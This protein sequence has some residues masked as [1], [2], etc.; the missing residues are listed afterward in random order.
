MSRTIVGVM[1]PGESATAADCA[2][3][4]RLGHL[5]ALQGWVTLTGGRP[6]GVMEAA[7]RG[8]KRAGGTTVGVL[9]ADTAA[10]ASDAA[11]IR[12]VTGLGEG[13]NIINVLSSQIVIVCGMSTGTASETALALKTA[14]H[15]VLLNVPPDA[16]RF[17]SALGGSF[18]HV[19]S[20]PEEAIAV[21]SRLLTEASP[22][23]G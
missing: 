22:P 15:T 23:S 21:A 10:H 16:A 6:A 1:G 2:A 14:R 17:W 13:R 5:I 12:I 4:D 8:A 9:P 11:D 20:T 3:A 7:L 18:L 19:A